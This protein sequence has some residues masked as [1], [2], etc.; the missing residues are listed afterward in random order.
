MT[1][2][3]FTPKEVSKILKLHWQ[4]VLIYIK[5]GKLPAVRLPKGY[6]V[7]KVDLDNFIETNRT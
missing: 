1:E 3:L 2:E 4:T 5:N 6:R 7:K